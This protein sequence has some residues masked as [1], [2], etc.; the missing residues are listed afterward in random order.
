MNFTQNSE[1]NINSFTYLLYLIMLFTIIAISNNPVFV[2]LLTI[3]CLIN[4]YYL[5]KWNDFKPMLHFVL[6]T[7]IFIFLINIFYGSF[8]LT[9][10]FKIPLLYGYQIDITCESLLYGITSSIKFLATVAVF[11]I[12]F[13]VITID[14]IISTLSS[15]L[16]KTAI[17]LSLCLKAIP[18]LANKAA[19]LKDIIKTRKL[20]NDENKRWQKYREYKLLA[21]A[22]ILSAI[23]DSLKTAEAIQARGFINKKRTNIFQEKMN[24]KSGYLLADIIFLFIASVF[25]LYKNIYDYSFYPKLQS[26]AFDIHNI[27]IFS[28][29]FV[30]IITPS[31]LI[32]RSHNH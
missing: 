11:F 5:G 9:S 18:M 13:S 21:K 4:I 22:L 30:S 3:G 31:F 1:K 29:I 12:F 17:T 26:F 27:S 10:L 23:E 28:V 7:S 16:P 24:K 32:S 14:N 19:K 25:G 15:H 20:N 2:A 6:L 8:G